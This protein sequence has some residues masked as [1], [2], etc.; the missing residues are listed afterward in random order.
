MYF[1]CESE[2]RI[3]IAHGYVYSS[4]VCGTFKIIIFEENKI[5]FLWLR[6]RLPLANPIMLLDFAKTPS[7]LAISTSFQTIHSINFNV[8]Y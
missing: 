3:F 8:K 5:Y 2:I 7:L 4:K 6:L 1:I